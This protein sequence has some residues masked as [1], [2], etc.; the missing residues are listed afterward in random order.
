MMTGVAAEFSRLGESGAAVAVL[1][2]AHVL[3]A[4]AALYQTASAMRES[5]R[6]GGLDE[7]AG[8]AD[9]LD[10]AISS[11]RI[12]GSTCSSTLAAPKLRR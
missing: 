2:E 7:K 5:D 4:E 1:T 11:A 6:Y 8:F 3:A 9:R 12:T 10:R